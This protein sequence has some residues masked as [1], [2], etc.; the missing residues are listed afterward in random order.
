[1]AFFGRARICKNL[2][3]PGNDSTT[4][5]VYIKST[6]VYVPSSELGLSNP[7][8][9]SDSASVPLPP[10][11]GERGHNRLQVRGWG[12]PIPTTAIKSLALC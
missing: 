9:V 11:P 3:S 5:Y 6:S 1:M 12:V 8:L 7:S 2:W 4:K 10:N